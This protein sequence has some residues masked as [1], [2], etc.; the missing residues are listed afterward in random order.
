[1]TPAMTPVMTPAMTPVLTPA[2]S[3]YCE[4]TDMTVT[5]LITTRYDPDC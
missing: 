2:L 5:K 3:C 1:M 4:H